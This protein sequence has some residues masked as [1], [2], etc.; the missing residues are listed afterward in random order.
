MQTECIITL[1]SF[2]VIDLGTIKST[3]RTSYWSSIVTKVTLVLPCRISEILELLYA[4]IS[5][6]PYPTPI[7]AEIMGCVPLG[8]YP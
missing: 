5:I 4:E 6:L 1:Q 8:I 7:T 2:N 3:Y